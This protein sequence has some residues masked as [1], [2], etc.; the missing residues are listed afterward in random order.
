VLLPVRTIARPGWRAWAAKPLTIT[1]S[2]SLQVVAQIYPI[3]DHAMTFG[4]TDH[5]GLNEVIM[6]VF[7][8]EAPFSY[9]ILEEATTRTT[10][11]TLART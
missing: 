4:D 1:S 3:I 5:D 11:S 2:D 6:A 7:D 8:P 9:R 10:R